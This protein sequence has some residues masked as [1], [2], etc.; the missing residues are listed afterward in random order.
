M[1]PSAELVERLYGEHAGAVRRFARSRNYDLADD[2]VSE[3]FA[4]AMRRTDAIPPGAERAW[5]ISVAENVLR[6]LQRKEY[7][8]ASLPGVLQPHTPASSPPHEVP[9]VGPALG[10]LAPTERDVL[11]LTAFE[12]LSSAEAAE[13]LGLSPGS[14]RNAM[15]RAR[16][17][18]AIQLAGFG[19]L[20]LVPI[21][22]FF[23]RDRGG[24]QAPQ[25]Q[26]LAQTLGRALSVE[27]DAT[28]STG[29]RRGRY[30]VSVD[31]ATGQQR[32][33]LPGG[34]V[35][36][37]PL[38]GPLH[39]AA[40]P[41]LTPAERR[42]VRRTNAD[43]LAALQ[44]ITSGDLERF[45]GQARRAGVQQ[46]TTGSGK[47]QVTV[48]RGPLT[49]RDG[50]EVE[51]RVTLAGAPAVLRQLQVR[52]ASQPGAPWTTVDVRRWRVRL[53][54][55]GSPPPA[56]ASAPG[57]A[58]SAPASTPAGPTQGVWKPAGDTPGRP[59]DAAPRPSAGRAVSEREAAQNR[60]EVAAVPTYTGE[61]GAVRHTKSVTVSFKVTDSPH[62][63]R[64]YTVSS[65]DWYETGGGQR[66]RTVESYYDEDRGRPDGGMER[67]GSPD[68]WAVLP[69]DD[70]GQPGLGTP[71]VALWCEPVNTAMAV[72][73]Q[74]AIALQAARADVSSLPTGPPIRGRDTRV[75][76][77]I[78]PNPVASTVAP[79]EFRIYLDAESAVP[80][81]RTWQPPGADRIANRTDYSVWED[82]PAGGPADDLA[83]VLPE[84]FRLQKPGKCSA[85]ATTPELPTASPQAAAATPAS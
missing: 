40:R 75:L 84:R 4:I 71:S 23:A 22:F 46:R 78:M 52:P 15:V 9:S 77:R 45:L 38:D 29:A 43:A 54:G 65:E 68:V 17:N 39:V 12:G 47:H 10:E 81:R 56:V 66:F 7:R 19:I 18:L 3:T 51:L 74:E 72:P 42:E 80:L 5:L 31:R 61:T 70:D 13:R 11:M 37:G 36:A 1:S 28:V 2:V 60:A 30:R 57:G 27:T 26:R 58:A 44:T 50:R 76:I 25:A 69:R 48:L 8:A 24:I 53:P 67:W 21:I 64:G 34:E 6:N 59:G 82:I 20:M 14:T 55:A 62:E 33:T 41:G 63:T 32:I 49:T 73:D 79:G 83:G 85:T 16:R 35:A